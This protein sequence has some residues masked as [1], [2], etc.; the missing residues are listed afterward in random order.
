[1]K[2]LVTPENHTIANMF[3]PPVCPRCGHAMRLLTLE[4]HFKFPSLDNQKYGCA[5]GASL[6]IPVARI[7]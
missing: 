7:D 4:P 3:A 5:C 6:T 2:Q 1:M